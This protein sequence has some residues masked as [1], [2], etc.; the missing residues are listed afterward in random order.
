M[1]IC[2]VLKCARKESKDHVGTL[3]KKHA[4]IMERTQYHT[5][6][7]NNHPFRYKETNEKNNVWKDGCESVRSIQTPMINTW[8]K[9]TERKLKAIEDTIKLLTI[10]LEKYDDKLKDLVKTKNMRF[11]R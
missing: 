2:Q 11:V 8:I 3:C 7:I 9:T 10:E 5:Y 4:E 6:G 1:T